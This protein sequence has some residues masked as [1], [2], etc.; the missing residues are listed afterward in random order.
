MALFALYSMFCNLHSIIDQGYQFII[1]FILNEQN[2]CGFGIKWY[3]KHV[4]NLY[5]RKQG[6]TVNEIHL[7]VLLTKQERKIFCLTYTQVEFEH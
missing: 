3:E 5:S 6:S 1:I 4:F 2:V 7:L